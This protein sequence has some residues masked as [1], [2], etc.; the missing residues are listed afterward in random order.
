MLIAIGCMAAEDS[1]LG[2][3]HLSLVAD[4]S[5][6]I[7][8]DIHDES[9]GPAGV[10]SRSFL[11]AN[12]KN[13]SKSPVMYV[14]GFDTIAWEV[15]LVRE[16]HPTAR[17]NDKPDMTPVA[18]TAFGKLV[19]THISR[20]SAELL[21]GETTRIVLYLGRLYDVSLN[22]KYSIGGSYSYRVLGEIKALKI[23]NF[24]VINSSR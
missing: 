2:G 8:V 5:I 1:P 13:I 15:S 10:L 6:S 11:A 17:E 14:Q 4:D 23:P 9:K 16:G 19:S 12:I 21:P 20:S 24:D 3:R 7:S 22:G 18:K